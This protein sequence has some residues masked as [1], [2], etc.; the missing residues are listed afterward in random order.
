MPKRLNRLAALALPAALI[1]SSACAPGTDPIDAQPAPGT[2]V[3][4]SATEVAS[5]A[6]TA[7]MGEIE[8]AELALRKSDDP[9]IESFAN[10]MIRDHTRANNELRTVMNSLGIRPTRTTL[11]NRLSANTEETIEALRTFDG[12][13][14]DRA[15]IET[16]DDTHEWLLTTLNQT[17]IP[18]ATD[19]ELDA[20]LV[21]LRETVENHH[22]RAEEIEDMMD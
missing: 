15:Y 9:A 5:T 22:E 14:F 17:L 21:W 8:M 4:L 18:A 16:Q 13:A 1:M 12:D 20:Y 2:T 3:I 10:Y 7:N 11:T 6:W 19:N